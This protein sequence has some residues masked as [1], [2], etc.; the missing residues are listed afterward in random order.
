MEAKA[1]LRVTADDEDAYI[2]TL[3]TVARQWVENHTKRAL[4][5][6]TWDLVCDHFP[7]EFKMPL[8]PLQSVTSIA[9]T[10]TAGNGQTLL[11]ADYQVDA[12]GNLHGR[13]RPASGMSWP[14]TRAEMNAVTVKFVAG[15]G[16]DAGD[17]PE[18]I[19]QAILIMIAELRLRREDAIVGAPIT[20]V[21]M[22]VEAL[23]SSYKTWS[24][25]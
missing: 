7:G 11:A 1:H 15:F 9:Y 17:V 24:F 13:I 23:L 10:D 14:K 20:T 12:V 8:P 6:Q 4:I 2:T 21:P 19:R 5:T 25:A 22:G 16:D 3:I 18:Q